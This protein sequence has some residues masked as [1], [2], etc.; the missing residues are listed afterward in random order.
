MLTIHQFRDHQPVVVI[1]VSPD[2]RIQG[3]GCGGGLDEPYRVETLIFNM[4]V[5]RHVI[6]Q[7]LSRLRIV[8]LVFV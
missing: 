4:W 6:D 2:V 3:V 8:R 1:H 5:A 7:V